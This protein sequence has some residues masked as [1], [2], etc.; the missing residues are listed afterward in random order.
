MIGQF[1]YL[2]SE[3]IEEF[4]YIHKVREQ[5]NSQHDLGPQLFG[6]IFDQKS[7]GLGMATCPPLYL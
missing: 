5:A 3:K 6:G 1:M 4:D 7:G 2:L